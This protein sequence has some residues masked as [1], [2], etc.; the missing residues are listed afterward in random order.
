MALQKSKLSSIKPDNF[1]EPDYGSK[2][3]TTTREGADRSKESYRGRKEATGER[4]GKRGA[5]FKEGEEVKGRRN[6]VRG[7][8]FVDFLTCANNDRKTNQRTTS[9]GLPAPQPEKKKRDLWNTGSLGGTDDLT[10]EEQ[11]RRDEFEKFRKQHAASSSAEKPSEPS[12][13]AITVCILVLYLII[14]GKQ[15]TTQTRT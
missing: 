7:D 2:I 14:L 4:G 15:Y 6:E 10:R 9:D 1:S 3:E 13:E 8:R 11:D 5:F 12:T